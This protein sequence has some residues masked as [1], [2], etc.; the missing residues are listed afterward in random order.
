MIFKRIADKKNLEYILNSHKEVCEV[1]FGSNY[2]DFKEATKRYDHFFRSNEETLYDMVVASAGGYP[3]DINFIQ[4]H[5]SIH[6]AASFVKDGGKLIIYSEC[7]DGIGNQAF[8]NLFRLGGW[9][10]IFKEMEAKY[11]NNAG[12]ALAMITKTRR[13]HIHFV[14]S[15]DEETCNLMG[16]L[17]TES[18]EVQ[19]LIDK[20][21]GDI[22]YIQNASLLYK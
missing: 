7:R 17:K 21:T 8:M 12:T 13:I 16:A 9:D 11:M 15:L 14:T 10:Q 3:K 18:E 5:K 4:A 22:A 1:H 6:N 20:E 19:P 2:G